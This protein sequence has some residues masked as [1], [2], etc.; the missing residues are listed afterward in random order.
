MKLSNESYFSLNF[1]VRRSRPNKEGEFPILLR[2]TMNGQRAEVYTNRYVAPN[3]W[4]AS[5]TDAVEIFSGECKRIPRPG[6][7]INSERTD[8][9]L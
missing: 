9:E 3:N 2:I 4:D 1:M 5:P 8:F 7:F 6:V